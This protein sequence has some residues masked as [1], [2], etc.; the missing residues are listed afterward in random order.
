MKPSLFTIMPYQP[1]ARVFVEGLIER[2]G[3]DPFHLAQAK[4]FVPT[5]RSVLSLRQAFLEQSRSKALLLPQIIPLGSLESG[6]DEEDKQDFFADDLLKPAIDPL[7]R[8]IMLA[9][10][11]LEKTKQTPIRRFDQALLIAESLLHFL[12]QLHAENIPLQNLH[13]LCG[14]EVAEHVNM[15]LEFF[16]LLA[17]DWPQILKKL[18][19]FEPLERRAALFLKYME[20][21]KRN[22]PETLHIVAGTTG[23]HALTAEFM[24]IVSKLPEGFIVLPGFDLS[25]SSEKLMALRQE[26]T[27]PQHGFSRLFHKCAWQ[28][29]QVHPW[30]ESELQNDIQTKTHFHLIKS[31]FDGYIPPNAYDEKAL[32]NLTRL[33]LEHSQEEAGV[34]ACILK[35]ALETP[36]QRAVVITPDRNLARRIQAE[37]KRFNLNI[38][39]S[40]GVPL[41]QTPFFIFLRLIA[42]MVSGG[43]QKKDILAVLKHE[44]T[45]WTAELIEY[46]ELHWRHKSSEKAHDILNHKIPSELHEKLL[47]VFQKTQEFKNKISKSSIAFQE[48]FQHHLESAF[49]I[50][51]KDLEYFFE[52]PVGEVFQ[53][54]FNQMMAT[55]LAQA[56]YIHGEDYLSVFESLAQGYAVREESSHFHTRLMILGP[57]EARML[58]ADTVILAGLN[59]GVW[60]QESEIDFWL[61][62]NMRENLGLPPPERRI[63]LSAHDFVQGFCSKN[64]YLTRSL[65]TNGQPTLPS[66]WLTR[67][68]PVLERYHL[69]ETFYKNQKPWASW[70][71]MLI[72]PTHIEPTKA[73]APCPPFA[74]RPVALS[75]TQI[76]LWMRDPYSIFA[77]HIL[78]LKPLDPLV[79]EGDKAFIGTFI[80][81]LL[82]TFLNQKQHMLDY[83]KTQIQHWISKKIEI[84]SLEPYE[85][86]ILQKKCERIFPWFMKGEEQ[87]LP[88][89]KQSYTEIEGKINFKTS[90]A[91]FTLKARADRIDQFVNE[92]IHIIDYK[93]G[94]PPTLKEITQG[95]APQ[96]ALEGLI[97]LEGGFGKTLKDLQTLQLWHLS[98]SPQKEEGGTIITLSDLQDLLE[99]TKQGFQN[100]SEAYTKDT[101]PYYATP[102]LDK[103]P[104]FHDYA[105]L[106]RLKEWANLEDEGTS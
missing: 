105:H 39:D 48:L 36:H 49:I 89:L 104:R 54:F 31:A 56:L 16:H 69:K 95:F 21:L 7:H 4:I 47:E 61:N 80:H 98:G 51:G 91:D 67:F 100:L 12:D 3:H 30:H 86:H 17:K 35:H 6:F 79:E 103:A 24:D 62:R 70:Y 75:V 90:K 66:R 71:Q 94:T 41:A 77:K 84:L 44:Y 59:E 26:P 87:R 1:F 85:K 13:D 101:T 19:L 102:R 83:D 97:A 14:H 106:E 43:F 40:A 60:P 9:Q 32:K 42:G 81:S 34:I 53:N 73:P 2:F 92:E 58:D 96:I 33:D 99:S 20:S 50:S 72:T 78:K 5:Q 63:G 64:V 46:L 93:T 52:G 68:D 37:L 76:E 55:H 23:S 11:V 15:N 65:K 57:M 10:L 88:F 29:D 28:L 38:L 45:N 74:L 8:K 82:E 25:L 18:N 22:S 27:H